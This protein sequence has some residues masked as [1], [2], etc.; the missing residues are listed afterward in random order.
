MD[1]SGEH[2]ELRRMMEDF[3]ELMTMS[4]D[5]SCAAL[6]HARLLFS[7]RFAS[8]MAEE[9]EYL[10]VLTASPAGSRFLPILPE[11]Q[12]RVRQLRADYSAHVQKWTPR[13]ID[14]RWPD[15]VSAVLVLQDKFR[16]LM[17]WE[18]KSFAF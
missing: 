5:G 14:Q 2:H 13:N 15:Y 1:C 6:P 18:E 16:N 12:D 17:A 10:R 8:H 11:Y 7:R 3:A 9:A 4:P